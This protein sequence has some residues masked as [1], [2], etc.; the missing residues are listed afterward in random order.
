MDNAND[1][2]AN[3]DLGQGLNSL[4]N[5]LLSSKEVSGHVTMVDPLAASP[6]MDMSPGLTYF[7]DGGDQGPMNIEIP[8][9]ESGDLSWE[10]GIMKMIEG[11]LS[12]PLFQ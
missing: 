10:N 6:Q 1:L 7:L 4:L 2:T 5:D 3:L 9:D 12:M 8:L 11:E